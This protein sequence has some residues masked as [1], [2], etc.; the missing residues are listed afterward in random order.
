MTA[1]YGYDSANAS[2]VSSTARRGSSR[3]AV[4][5]RVFPTYD[6]LYV[7]RHH[8]EQSI[9]PISEGRAAYPDH[10]ISRSPYH[11][12]ISEPSSSTYHSN[13]PCITPID[14]TPYRNWPQNPVGR[15][16][17]D[18]PPPGAEYP[19][20]EYALEARPL[21]THDNVA[22]DEPYPYPF[23]GYQQPRDQPYAGPSSYPPNQGQTPFTNGRPAGNYSP[24]S[25]QSED[26]GDGKPRKR[27]GNLPKPITDILT[28]W[29][30]NHLEH[31][32]PNEE[33][34]QYLMRQ[35]GLQ[36]SKHSYEIHSAFARY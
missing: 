3:S 9:L 26:M 23:Y 8:Q 14:R 22:R 1:N 2:P 4:N 11:S 17:N 27:R 18:Y 21:H 10:H 13:L 16:Y 31:P 15:S 5:S 36:L 20:S 12:P 29:F 33:E 24:N 28:D 32:Y 30:V 19:R 25:H 7:S 6:N 35:T 34:K